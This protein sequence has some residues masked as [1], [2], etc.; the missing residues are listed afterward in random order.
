VPVRTLEG[1]K[2]Y[3]F[4]VAVL[5]GGAATAAA[6]GPGAVSLQPASPARWDLWGEAGWLG[7]N[8]AEVAPD[9]DDWYDAG[10]GGVGLGYHLTPHLRSELRAAVA[11]E[12]R[13]LEEQRVVVPGQPFPVFRLRE[14]RYRT[15][16]LAA[17]L[18]YQ[19]FENQWFHPA[20][21]GGFELVHERE[22]GVGGSVRMR[23]FVAAGFKWYGNERVFVRSDVRVSLFGNG[24]AARV[25]WSAGVGVDL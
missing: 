3:V 5:L 8:K 19:F 24:A 4:V 17:A 18:A 11:G 10:F 7:H 12:G 22:A 25:T 2:P 23:P 16:S 6:Q 20:L 15:A 1:K 9:W 13:V 21:G 14:H